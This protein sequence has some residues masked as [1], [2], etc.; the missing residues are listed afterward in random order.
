MEL[1]RLSRRSFTS[2]TLVGCALN[3]S[4]A[5]AQAPDPCLSDSALQRR[6]VMLRDQAGVPSL[7]VAVFTAD[8]EIRT[9]AWGVGDIRT[10]AAVTTQDSY[11][12]GSLTKTVTG[13]VVG[14]LVDEGRLAFDDTIADLLPDDANEM[15][16]GLRNVT[17]GQL[18][19]HTSGL[20]GLTNR[21]EIGAVFGDADFLDSFDGGGQEQREQILPFVLALDPEFAPGAEASYSNL[22]YILAGAIAESATGESWDTLVQSRI[23]EPLGISL[24]VGRPVD[25]GPDQ[26][27]GHYPGAGGLRPVDASDDTGLVPLV[28][29]PSG[30]LTA[31]PGD[32][33]TLQQA[34]LRG[35]LGGE[36]GL[37]IS[38]ETLRLI[39]IPSGTVSQYGFGSA[40]GEIDGAYVSG[41][42][43]SETT[44]LSYNLLVPGDQTGAVVST[45]AG[46]FQPSFDDGLNGLGVMRSM[47]DFAG[48][49]LSLIPVDTALMSDEGVI[50][51]SLER[52][53]VA[54]P[55]SVGDLLAAFE[56]LSTTDAVAL[57]NAIAPDDARI[58][59]RLVLAPVEMLAGLQEA[60]LLAP[61]LFGQTRY[62]VFY[63]RQSGD[64]HVDQTDGSAVM[65]ARLTSFAMDRRFSDRLSAGAAFSY[66]DATGELDFRSGRAETEGWSIGGYARYGDAGGWYISGQ[67]IWSDQSVR[68]RRAVSTPVFDFGT[69]STERDGAAWLLE[70][71]AG[72]RFSFRNSAQLTP[73]L[74]LRHAAAEL[75]GAVETGSDAPLSLDA[76]GLSATYG[77]AGLRASTETDVS[78]W[79][80]SPGASLLYAVELSDDATGVIA[81]F[82]DSADPMVF[83][84]ARREDDWFEYGLSVGAQ[85]GRYNFALGITGDV[86]RD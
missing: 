80:V 77:R 12:M 27:L 59:P 48:G 6:T 16:E 5:N 9:A 67:A 54:D 60:Q 85:R 72:Y 4:V 52:G 81:R 37:P 31:T 55:G 44:F 65:T 63:A 11:A 40:G 73:F 3:I 32:W 26:P 66:G 50:F 17:L 42:A 61:A 22:G 28:A 29:S 41:G 36:S 2:A 25:L 34:Q 74:N 24:S 56:G 1:K 75:D 43:G 82:A 15:S 39:H 13:L 70:A 86:N 14:S 78:G 21:D 57:A 76:Q 68:S 62:S 84:P 33:G 20:P 83:H 7:S 46:A 18:L 58:A 8:G 19:E 35:L 23:A 64:I 53:C 69:A 49:E 30:G 51:R 79:R 10:G 47:T 45:N 38:T 71:G